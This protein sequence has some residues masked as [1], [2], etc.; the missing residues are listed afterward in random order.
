MEALDR[1]RTSE[2]LK[3]CR[4]ESENLSKKKSNTEVKQVE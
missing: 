2:I 1:I 3:M 4:S